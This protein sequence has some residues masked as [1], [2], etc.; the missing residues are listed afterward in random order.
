[1]F[2]Q[3]ICMVLKRAGWG[4][5]RIYI[6]IGILQGKKHIVYFTTEFMLSSSIKEKS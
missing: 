5:G 2:F 6:Y 1:V 4:C 3:K